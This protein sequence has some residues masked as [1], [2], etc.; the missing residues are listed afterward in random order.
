MEENAIAS[1]LPKQNALLRIASFSWVK[2]SVVV[3]V[4]CFL[5]IVLFVY[6]AVSKLLDHQK[7]SIE[8][9]KSPLLTNFSSLVA[10]I[11]PSIEILISIALSIRSLRLIA[12]YAAFSLMVMFTAYLIAIL[13]FSFYVPCTCGGVL[14]QMNWDTHIIFNCVF[15]ALAL[16]AIFLEP[17]KKT[18]I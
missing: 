15:I 13:Q 12:L 14:Q 5:F 16:T 3:E 4:I 17:N 10:W 1:K 18:N 2:R 11:I 9:S 7:F 8:L 6:A